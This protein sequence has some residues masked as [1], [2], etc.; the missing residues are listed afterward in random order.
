MIDSESSDAK[1]TSLSS[2]APVFMPPSQSKPLSSL[3]A[4]ASEWKP[5]ATAPEWKPA[6]T[7]VYVYNFIERRL[8]LD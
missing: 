6:N 2:M 1:S 7:Q 5:R 3:S 4:T 8:L